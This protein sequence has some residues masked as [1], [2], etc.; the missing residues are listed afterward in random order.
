[1]TEVQE[2]NGV[3]LVE[4]ANHETGLFLQSGYFSTREAA[5]ARAVEMET[6]EQI[7]REMLVGDIA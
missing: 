4:Y 2:V 6:A 5:E 3:F 7:N 1:M